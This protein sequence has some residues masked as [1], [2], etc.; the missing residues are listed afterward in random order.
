M[1][2]PPEGTDYVF[3]NKDLKT[4]A[5]LLDSN[6]DKNLSSIRYT[7]VPNKIS[8]EQF[9]SNYFYRVQLL[10]KEARLEQVNPVKPVEENI[11]EKI[12]VTS[13]SQ[14]TFEDDANGSSVGYGSDWEKELQEELALLDIDERIEEVSDE[15]SDVYT[16]GVT[17]AADVPVEVDVDEADA[18][19]QVPEEAA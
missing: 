5:I 2:P 3:D 10:Q 17:D 16:D 18:E 1:L 7:L 13:Q 15:N 19:T 11:P 4:A 8:D 6:K 14:E 9:W 12:L